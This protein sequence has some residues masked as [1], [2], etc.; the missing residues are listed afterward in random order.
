MSLTI[1][2]AEEWSRRLVL[3]LLAIVQ[4]KLLQI[5]HLRADPAHAAR[6]GHREV[7][8]WVDCTAQQ[9]E[10]RGSALCAWSPA[11]TCVLFNVSY[12]CPE[13]VLANTRF[14]VQTE[15]RKR[16]RPSPPGRKQ[17]RDVVEEARL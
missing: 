8:G 3:V 14:L 5:R 6:P 4:R 12:V 16:T 7:C 9:V 1:S 15:S 17:C 13:P 11:E 2:E 10:Q